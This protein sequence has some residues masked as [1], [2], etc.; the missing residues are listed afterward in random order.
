[1]AERPYLLGDSFSAAD[2]LMGSLLMFFRTVMPPHAEY[3][4][5]LERLSARPAL[6]R[7]SVKDS[8]PQ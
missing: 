8:Q 7:A 5:W 1:L 2:I 3:D 6:G 4:A